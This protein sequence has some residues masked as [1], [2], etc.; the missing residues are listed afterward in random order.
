MVAYNFQAQFAD[1]IE[2]GH[3]I[4]T[5]RPVGKRKHAKK[6]DRLQLYTGM[7]TKGC[8]KLRDA[9]CHDSYRINLYHDY[10]YSFDPAEIWH[11]EE[12]ARLAASEGFESYQDM[13]RWFYD[14]YGELPFHGVRV[15]WL[16]PVID[17]IPPQI[18]GVCQN[19]DVS[20]AD[21]PVNCRKFDKQKKPTAAR[22]HAWVVDEPLAAAFVAGRKGGA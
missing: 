20:G 21:Q 9:V 6:G 13:A 12:C 7:R 14:R 19:A 3:K 16:V 22:C 1:A 18:C 4:S 8:R 10:A 15:T 5:I 11:D 2:R 17:T